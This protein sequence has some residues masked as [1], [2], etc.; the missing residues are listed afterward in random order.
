MSATFLTRR[1]LAALP[2]LLG[3]SIVL[4]AVL[5]LA[6]GGPLDMY[7]DIPGVSPEALA[8]MKAAFGLD[9]PVWEQYLLWVGSFLQGNWGYSIRTARPVLRDIGEALPATLLLG[10]S[11]LL[12][13]FMVA[14]PLGVLSAARRDTKLDTALTLVSFSGISIPVFWL[15]MMGQLLFS[16]TLH[17]LPSGGIETIG[18]GAAPDRILHLVMPVAILSLA[19]IAS[20]SRYMR[21]SMIEVLGQDHIRT[22][23]AKGQS[24]WGI[25]W[26]HGFRNAMLPV[27]TVMALDLV[28]VVSGAVIT[29]TVFAWPGIGHLFITSMNGRDYPVLMGLMM[30]GSCALVFGNIAADIAYGLIDPRISHE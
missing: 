21:A 2:L 29:E 20:W 5:H 11:S 1:L 25:V 10:G 17:W 27:V 23:R 30:I 8:Q 14:I 9:K 19:T 18:N 15:A 3:I 26:R 12:L 28:N 6:P 7:A 22:A 4:F 24:G 16:I 13:S